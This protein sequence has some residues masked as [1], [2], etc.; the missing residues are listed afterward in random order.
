MSAPH[1]SSRVA[2]PFPIVLI[3]PPGSGK[4]TVAG[5]LATRLGVA[6]R[7]TD[8]DIVAETGSSIADI[9]LEQGEPAFRALEREAVRR[10]LAGH[11]GVLALGG[12]S[13]LDPG[14]QQALVG[15]TV[16]FLDVGVADAARRVGLN[17]S[18][19]L[20]VGNPRAAWQK[21]MEERRPI[22][23]RV[24]TVVVETDG[25]TPEQ[26]A[27]LVLEALEAEAREGWAPEGRPPVGAP[28]AG[29]A[30]AG[31]TT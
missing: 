19:P 25:R 3:G 4:T 20:L 7:D 1:P 15:R 23:Q 29:E 16:V 21:L 26:V 22:Y 30:P 9:F 13:V 31:E 24:A 5:V 18:R 28:P 10:A 17:A 6:V 14:A 27:E 8:A 11:D 12:G 2:S